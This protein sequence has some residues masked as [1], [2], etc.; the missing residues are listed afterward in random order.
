M[1]RVRWGSAALYAKVKLQLV[2]RQEALT[3]NKPLEMPSESQQKT[4]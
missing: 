2:D 1:W 4:H 3:R